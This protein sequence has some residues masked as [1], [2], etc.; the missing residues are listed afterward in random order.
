MSAS[1]ASGSTEIIAAASISEAAG[2]VFSAL[3]DRTL[4]ISTF[5]SADGAIRPIAPALIAGE[6]TGVADTAA[7][8]GSAVTADDY[9]N[10]TTGWDRVE[11]GS[12]MV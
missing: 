12:G 6:A 11:R 7:G 8:G 2:Q 4:H 9:N 1:S 10:G 3:A 5:T